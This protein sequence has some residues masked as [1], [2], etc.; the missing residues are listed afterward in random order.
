MVSSSDHAAPLAASAP[1]T[2]PTSGSRHPA[3]IHEVDVDG[4]A[5]TVVVVVDVEGEPRWKLTV[6]EEPGQPTYAL[7]ET[8]YDQ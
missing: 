8:F 5:T 7:L 1:G 3:W 2:E 6:I 4:A